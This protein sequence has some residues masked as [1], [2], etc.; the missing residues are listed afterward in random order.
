MVDFDR[1]PGRRMLS[2]VA[3]FC[4]SLTSLLPFFFHLAR[5]GEALLADTLHHKHHA[6]VLLIPSI[7]PPRLAGPRRRSHCCTVRVQR[8]EAPPVVALGLDQIARRRC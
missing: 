3:S 5:V 4:P 7:T 2:Q 1:P 6:V 8:S